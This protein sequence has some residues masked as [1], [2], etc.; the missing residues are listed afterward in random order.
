M[1]ASPGVAFCPRTEEDDRASARQ[2]QSEQR[3]ADMIVTWVT[4]KTDAPKMGATAPKI[5]TKRYF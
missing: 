5:P 3:I 2:T 1:R 4:G